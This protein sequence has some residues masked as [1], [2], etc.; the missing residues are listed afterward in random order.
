[1]VSVGVYIETRI[2]GNG[3]REMAR[4]EEIKMSL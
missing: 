4:V 2:I 3:N 1:M